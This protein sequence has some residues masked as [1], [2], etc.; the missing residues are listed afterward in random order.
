MYVYSDYFDNDDEVGIKCLFMVSPVKYDDILEM[1]ILKMFRI[2]KNRILE[3]YDKCEQIFTRVY[4]DDPEIGSY[5]FKP[6]YIEQF[7]IHNRLHEPNDEKYFQIILSL[8]NENN[9]NF[10]KYRVASRL[11]N[12]SIRFHARFRSG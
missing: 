8:Q 3:F 11:Q 5:Q 4:P 1:P 10:I 6:E 9:L 12:I 2:D 7:N